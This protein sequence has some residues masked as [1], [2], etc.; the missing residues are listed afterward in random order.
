MHASQ[1]NVYGLINVFCSKTM[2]YYAIAAGRR[3]LTTGLVRLWGPPPLQGFRHTHTHD[4]TRALSG[5]MRCQLN[6]QSLCKQGAKYRSAACLDLDAPCSSFAT[7][8]Q[9]QSDRPA[10]HLPH[11]S[12]LT[13]LTMVSLIDL[14]S[15]SVTVQNTKTC[16][17]FVLSFSL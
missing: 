6:S 13:F 12:F 4:H 16:A 2:L 11:L 5:L 7:K 1:A 14:V 8:M 17:S 10:K 9:P 3:S 15:E